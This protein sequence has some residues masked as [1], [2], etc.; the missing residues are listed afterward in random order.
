MSGNSYRGIKRRDP[1][2]SNKRVLFEKGERM[3]KPK[4]VTL[5]ELV[6]KEQV[7][8]PCIWDC[9]SARAA[10]AIGFKAALLSGGAFAGSV[11]GMPDIGLITADDLVRE[12]EYIGACSPLPCI[13]D[14]DDG[15]GESPLNAYRTTARL[16][17]AGA[18]S[19]TVDDTTGYR[20]YNRW[21]KQLR[22]GQKDGTIDHPVVSKE[23]WLAKMR[24]CLDACEGT[25]CMLIAR[26]ECKLK[27]G[28]DD[29]IERCI[30]ARELGVEMTLIIG[31]MNLEEAQKVAKQVSG[32]KMWPDVMSRNGV[33]D[34]Q[35][36]DI[37]ALGF[38]LITMHILEKGAMYGMLDFGKH[39]LKDQNTLY[40]DQHNMGMEPEE[41]KKAFSM[42]QDKHW[43]EMEKRFW[44]PKT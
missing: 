20:G 43:L 29:A 24:A 10:E 30:R 11:C 38:N 14:A 8:A 26:T 31:L 32:W 3:K 28:L 27:Y 40:H 17:K 7:L 36:K 9:M 35:L 1:N 6:A 21:G 2:R 25:D 41:A 22:S 4:R 23:A 44:E 12:T 15:Y 19:L 42:D 34:V 33:P 13:I 16:A 37:E 5:R 18:M 39:V